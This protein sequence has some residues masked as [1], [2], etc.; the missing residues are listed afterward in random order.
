MLAA[1]DVHPRIARQILRHT[2]IS[3]TMEVYTH[4][5]SEQTRNALRKLG[6]TLDGGRSTEISGEEVGPLPSAS[7]EGQEKQA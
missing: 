3:V 5:P 1:L 7:E 4:V 6:A 2:Q